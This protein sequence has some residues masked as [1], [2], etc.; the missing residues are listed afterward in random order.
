M[1]DNR[2][3]RPVNREKR[4]VR[5]AGER[6]ARPAGEKVARTS[7]KR[8][9]LRRKKTEEVVNKS[10]K[11]TTGYAV[12]L[13]INLIILLAL[14]KLFSYSFN[15]AYK[16]F[17]DA[18]YKPGSKEMVTFTVEADST[19]MEIGKGLTDAGVI[20]DKYVFVAKVKVKGYGKKIC[21]GH[22]RLSPSMSMDEILKIIC[23]IEDKKKEE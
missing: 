4:P 18:R 13:L 2:E 20:D 21:A 19:S 8:A 17:G 15:F 16:V 5:P 9:I 3:K 23:R 14:V 7:K 12:S 1:S 10:L 22:Y 11:S 6:P